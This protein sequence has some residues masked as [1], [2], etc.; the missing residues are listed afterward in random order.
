MAARLNLHRVMGFPRRGVSIVLLAA[1]LAVAQPAHAD[2]HL[3][4]LSYNLHGLSPFIA[5]DN[6]RTRIAAIGALA[7]TYDVALFQEDFEY[8]GVIRRQ[9]TGSVGVCGNGST[10]DVRRLAA[11]I[12]FAP[13]TLFLPHFS[14][15]YGA[16]LSTFVKPALAQQDDVGREPY[17]VCDGWL[18]A[19]FD[20]WASKGYLRV[21]IRTP[22]GVIIDVYSTHLDAGRG[23][24]SVTT[25][26]RQLRMLAK[27]IETQ[28]GGRAV[29]VGGDFNIASDR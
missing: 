24:R 21:G 3:S 13:V 25:R 20:C 10:F 9:M 2:S 18:G 15:P 26:R 1:S 28:S 19:H 6:P 29:I 8:H 11:K 23:K 5:K 14:A 22:E 17:G 16:G 7:K 27:A 12:L 4:V